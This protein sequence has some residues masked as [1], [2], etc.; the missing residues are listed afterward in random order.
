MLYAGE[1]KE[2]DVFEKMENAAMND[3]AVCTTNI[4]IGA[5]NSGHANSSNPLTSFPPRGVTRIEM[6]MGVTSIFNRF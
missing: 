6:I 3:G 1:E 5:D 2:T 4:S